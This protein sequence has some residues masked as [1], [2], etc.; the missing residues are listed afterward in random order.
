[1]PAVPPNIGPVQA[2]AIGPT[3]TAEAA[4]PP[5]DQAIISA[6]HLDETLRVRL[7]RTRLPEHKEAL[8]AATPELHGLRVW[9]NGTD[10]VLI[11]E[12]GYVCSTKSVVEVI[13]LCR[14]ES[15]MGPGA[16][17]ALLS[18]P[19]V[20]PYAAVS[21]LAPRFTLKQKPVEHAKTSPKAPRRILSSVDMSKLLDGI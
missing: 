19:V 14:F 1:M 6:L 5:T 12:R 11:D 16:L 18:R 9:V 17:R 20:D 21:I 4:T 13:L 15:T 3:M 10:A 8:L 2:T 7:Q